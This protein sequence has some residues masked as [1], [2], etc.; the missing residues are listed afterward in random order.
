M[1]DHLA[2][3]FRRR[4]VIDEFGESVRRVERIVVP[5]FAYDAAVGSNAHLAGDVELSAIRRKIRQFQL[6]VVDGDADLNA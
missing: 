1:P 5:K 4:F 3:S 6:T 2:A